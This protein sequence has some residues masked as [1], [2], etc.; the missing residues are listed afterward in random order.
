[1]PNAMVEVDFDEVLHRTDA[2]GVKLLIGPGEKG[3]V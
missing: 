1:M 3:L 2:G